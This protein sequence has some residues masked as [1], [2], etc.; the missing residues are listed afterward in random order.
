MSASDA[1]GAARRDRGQAKDPV[2]TSGSSIAAR[3]IAA[4]GE[5]GARELLDV[6]T[7]PD[8]DRAA[9]IGRLHLRADCEW[10]AELLVDLEAVGLRGE[11]PSWPL[12]SD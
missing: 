8:A 11:V 4:V 5:A 2:T 9:L 12:L 1:R 6:L 7:R 3:V 10:L